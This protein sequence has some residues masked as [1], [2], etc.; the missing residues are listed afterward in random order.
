MK[1]YTHA[2]IVKAKFNLFDELAKCARSEGPLEDIR[3]AVQGK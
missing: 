1:S 3:E 2:G